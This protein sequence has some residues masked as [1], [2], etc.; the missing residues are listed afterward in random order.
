MNQYKYIYRLFQ[1][2]FFASLIFIWS[3]NRGEP[4]LE[5]GSFELNFTPVMGG[6]DFEA[7]FT[8]ENINGRKY[9]VDLF[10]MYVADITLIKESGEEVLLSEIELFD[11]GAGGEV[12][13]RAATAHGQVHSKS[14][15]ESK[16]GT[17]KELNLE[18]GFQIGS[19]QILP[20]MVL[21]TR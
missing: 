8:Y 10:L 4:P 1:V 6:Q 7:G 12:E 11:I 15:K 13:R 5:A 21:I 14:L 9:K 17:T 3:C 19:T 20:I 2:F 18:L 16:P